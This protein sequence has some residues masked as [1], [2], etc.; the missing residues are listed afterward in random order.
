MKSRNFKLYSLYLKCFFGAMIC[1]FIGGY[2]LWNPDPFWMCVAIVSAGMLVTI[3]FVTADVSA[4]Q[5]PV[6]TSSSGRVEYALSLLLIELG[7]YHEQPFAQHI[8]KQL[9]GYRPKE[10]IEAVNLCLA[11]LEKADRSDILERLHST[12]FK[13]FHYIMD[14]LKSK[15]LNSVTLHPCERLPIDV[16]Y[17]P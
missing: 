5:P 3:I 14:K 12:F 15:E 8:L 6:D 9:P 2:F 10:I 4:R 1:C 17:Y 11:G 13:N 16:K 7:V